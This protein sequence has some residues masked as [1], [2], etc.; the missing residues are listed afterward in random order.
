MVL[1]Q[2]TGF[3]VRLSLLSTPP[4]PT[5]SKP[6]T[7]SKPIALKP[8]ATTAYYVNTAHLNIREKA[9]SASKSLG[10]LNKN[11]RVQVISSANGWSKL[12]SGTKEVYV[13]SK[14]LSKNKAVAQYYTIRPGDNLSTIAKRYGQTV[15]QL[16]SWNNIKNA[17]KI[18]AG[19]KIRVK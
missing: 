7:P 1:R 12:K 14:Y 3:L 4:K 8:V 2:L 15:K 9:N 6:A 16:Q 19:Q 18:V 10:V 13:A 17:N 5:P 11:D